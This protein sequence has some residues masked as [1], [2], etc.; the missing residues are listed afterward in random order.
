MRTVRFVNW[1][2]AVKRL[3]HI[4]FE[5]DLWCDLTNDDIGWAIDVLGF[6]HRLHQ[7]ILDQ[8]YPVTVGLLK[9]LNPSNSMSILDDG[10]FS[11]VEPCFYDALEIILEFEHAENAN[12]LSQ[13]RSELFTP[14]TPKEQ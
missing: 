10:D 12:A 5:T 13:K 4:R 1:A 2:N 14:D 7:E 6:F 9:E 8:L 11:A 3:H